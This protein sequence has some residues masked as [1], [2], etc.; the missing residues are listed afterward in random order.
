M[1]LKQVDAPAYKDRLSQAGFKAEQKMAHY[2]ERAFKDDED[3]LVLNGIRLKSHD[4]SA[5]IDHL[6]IHRYG[7]IIIESKSAVG[8][9]KINDHG[10]WSRA[11]YD[12]GMASP[13]LQA[14]RQ[15]VFLLSYLKRSGLKPPHDAVR[16]LFR[17]IT[18][19]DVKMD[20]LVAVSDHG[21]IDRPPNL[22][23]KEVHKADVIPAKVGEIIAH[24]RKLESPFSLTL[25]AI[26]LQISRK[27]MMDIARFLT[28]SHVP[29][30]QVGRSK[31]RQEK[32]TSCR[33]TR[34]RT[35]FTCPKCGST[36]MSIQ[37]GKWGYYFRCAE[38]SKTKSITEY[39]PACG[40]QS[41]LRKAG[42][43]FYIRCGHCN[44]SRAFFKNPS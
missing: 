9:I 13:V 26:P 5:Q 21:N 36:N 40:Q 6:I 14:Q 11:G 28:R 43:Q 29:K 17:P 31:T 12:R 34:A 15:K 20:V 41:R 8:T 44:T 7:M 33:P 1:I 19:D 38:C 39:C 42:N 16:S 23:I 4:D 30:G 35:E 37:Y 27:L 22:E 2:L 3:I 32:V 10:E 24:Y 25:T 18:Y